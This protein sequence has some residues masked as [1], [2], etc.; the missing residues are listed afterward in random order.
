MKKMTIFMLFVIVSGFVACS[1]N[2]S[3]EAPS[4]STATTVT[5]PTCTV[6]TGIA[7]SCKVN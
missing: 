4:P 3:T 6:G 1:S 2:G 7:G 5:L